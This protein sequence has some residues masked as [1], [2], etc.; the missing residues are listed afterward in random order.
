MSMEV[1]REKQI[2]S[3]FVRASLECGHVEM[4]GRCRL[5]GR[6]WCL[7]LFDGMRERG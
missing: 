7:L 4:V 1:G 3:L 6:A 5:S 2:V